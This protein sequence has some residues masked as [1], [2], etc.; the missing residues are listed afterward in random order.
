MGLARRLGLHEQMDAP[1]VDPGEQRRALR[2]LARLNRL[3]GTRRRL[4]RRRNWGRVLDVGTGGADLPEHLVRLGEARFA[5]GLDNHPATLGAA[6]RLS[7][8]VTLVRGNALCLPF[9][10]ACFDTA[11]CHLFLHHLG[12][13]DSVAALAEMGRV[14]RRVV[15]IDLARSRW[16]LALVWLVTRFSG[17]RLARHDGPVSVRRA[18]TEREVRDLAARAGLAARAIPAG[19]GRWGLELEGK[20]AGSTAPP[21]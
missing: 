7:P 5:V 6:A 18:Y 21:A 11:M 8:D 4:G 15:A 12:E 2:A 17:S 3:G 9:P 10:D 19:P 20:R 1:D 16:M 13:E 14:A